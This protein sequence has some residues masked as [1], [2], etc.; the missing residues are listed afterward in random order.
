MSKSE[1]KRV[2]RGSFYC[3]PRQAVLCGL[4]RAAEPKTKHIEK[5]G[6]KEELP[7][8]IAKAADLDEAYNVLEWWRSN[9]SPLPHWSDAARRI[10]LIQ[11]SSA[12]AES[13]CYLSVL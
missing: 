9:A 6:L 12:A 11:P 7:A 5:A 8:Y 2:C 4:P 1:S 10:L 13:F 3:Q